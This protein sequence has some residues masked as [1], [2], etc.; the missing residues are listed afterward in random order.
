MTSEKTYF[1]YDRESGEKT[2][3]S[4]ELHD[5]FYR[6]AGR[7]RKKEQSRGRC[8][9]PRR[10]IWKCDGGCAG[11]EYRAA[12]DTVS[13]D[14]PLT[15]SEGTLGEFIPCGGR[16]MEEVIED[17]MLLEALIA[18]LRELDPEADI[19]IRIW[20]EHPDGISDR[21]VA[22]ELG[23]PQRTF[24]DQIK[25]YRADLRKLVNEG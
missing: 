20:A 12:G 6:E 11:C 9:C 18:R 1:I 7:I 25:R 16:P 21:A 8:V 24:A 14:R 17:R 15:D 13:L 19:M 5:D 10:C 3:V 22:R 2:P 4:K 23:R